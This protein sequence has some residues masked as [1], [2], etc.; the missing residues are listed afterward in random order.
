MLLV[1][2]HPP[3]AGHCH[4]LTPQSG[5]RAVGMERKTLQRK[6]ASQPSRARQLS[7]QCWTQ[8]FSPCF[9]LPR[10]VLDSHK[11]NRQCVWGWLFR[12]MKSKAQALGCRRPAKHHALPMQPSPFL[13]ETGPRLLTEQLLKVIIFSLGK[14]FSTICNCF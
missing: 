14:H 8:C 4:D 11:P 12:S 1:S 5:Q 7:L 6:M 13:S 10:S 3:A 2:E 9:S